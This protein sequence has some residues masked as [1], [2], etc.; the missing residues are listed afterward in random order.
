MYLFSIPMIMAFLWTGK[1]WI[2]DQVK[3]SWNK[4]QTEKQGLFTTIKDSHK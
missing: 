4:Y 3:E 1:W 2:W